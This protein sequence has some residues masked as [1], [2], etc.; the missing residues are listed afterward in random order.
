MEWLQAISFYLDK[1]LGWKNAQWGRTVLVINANPYY[2]PSEE[3]GVVIFHT[4]YLPL[5]ATSY[6]FPFLLIA[7][8]N[9]KKEKKNPQNNNNK[10]H[11]YKTIT[12]ASKNKSTV[13]WFLGLGNLV[14][15]SSNDN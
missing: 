5:I 7:S 13:K 14:R 8:H 15:I 6:F 2:L 11:L 9:E 1:Y 3:K 10:T 4:G 12:D